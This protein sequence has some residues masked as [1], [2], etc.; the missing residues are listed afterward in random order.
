[1]HCNLKKHIYMCVSAHRKFSHI[2]PDFL[3]E[4]SVLHWPWGWI[5]IAQLGFS[6]LRKLCR[7]SWTL[8]GTCCLSQSSRHSLRLFY[9]QETPRRPLWSHKQFS[10]LHCLVTY[11]RFDIT[12]GNSLTSLPY[13][14]PQRDNEVYLEKAVLG[15]HNCQTMKYKNVCWMV[16][17]HS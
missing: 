4:L 11:Q 5:R 17:T 13:Q 16:C 14:C 6:P 2:S 15:T 7:T 12:L 1:M 8:E 10:H 3:W 9:R